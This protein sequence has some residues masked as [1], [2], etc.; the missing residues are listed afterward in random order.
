MARFKQ[1]IAGVKHSLPVGFDSFLERLDAF[2]G[3]TNVSTGHYH[4]ARTH[5]D[6]VNVRL[7]GYDSCRRNYLLQA[8]GRGAVQVFYVKG[9]EAD[10]SKVTEF[11]QSQTLE[12]QLVA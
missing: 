9:S 1:K 5:G 6:E 3:E 11:V 12:G 4:H 2:F 7:V 10:F 8:K